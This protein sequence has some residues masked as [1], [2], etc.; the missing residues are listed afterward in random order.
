MPF[1]EQNAE[2]IGDPAPVVDP[3][4]LMRT[5]RSFLNRRAGH[6]M[7]LGEV[8]LP[9]PQQLDFFG[10][11]S[12]RRAAHA[13]RLHRHAG[14][15]PRAGPRGRRTARHRAR[16]AAG[17]RQTCQWAT[18]LRNHDELTL[19]KLGDAERQE[20]FAAFGPEPEMQ[21]YDRGLK[22]RLP[23]ML[24]GDPRRIRMAYSLMF[25]LPG[26]PTLYYGEEIGMGEDLEADGRMA[27]RTPMQWSAGRNGGFS[28]AAPSRLV[29]RVV[30]GAC[31]PEHV[32][33]VSQVHDPDSLWSFMR[34]L[35]SIRRTCP[36]LGWGTWSVVDQPSAQVLVQRCQ[37]DGSA[38]VTVHNL[39]ADPVTVDVPIDPRDEGLEAVDLMAEEVVTGGATT[40]VALEGYGFRWLRVRPAGDLAIP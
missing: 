25:S 39:G 12:G 40:S 9:H 20:V 15:L 27:V 30:P 11:D 38:V 31:G 37:L 35:I 22:R 29:Q 19:D 2:N 32:N 24:G 23:T 5:I 36:E 21:V 13:V 26:T 6:A 33:V 14:D 3:H 17:H 4:E 1:L 16:G 34:K 8:N 10:G 7:M 18:F 28:T